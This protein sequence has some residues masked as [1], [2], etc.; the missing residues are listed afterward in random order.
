MKVVVFGG[1]GLVGRATAAHFADEP[2]WEVTAV[3]RR[4]VELAGVEH[5][6]LDLTDEEACRSAIA[7]RAFAGTTHVVFAALQEAPDLY[8]G[9]LD[10]DLMER[11]LT[12]FRAAMEP[13][14]EHCRSTLEHVSLL[15]GAKAYG[16][17]VGRSPVPGKEDDGR[18]EHDNFYFLQEDRLRDLAA[19]E[20]WSWTVLRPQIV[21]GDSVG[22]P[23]NLLPAIGAYAAM[24]RAQGRALGFPGG[25]RSVQE[26][27]D[28]RLL[29]R[30]L[31]WAAAAPEARDEVFNVTNGDVFDWHEVWPAIA[32]A[33][34]MEVGDPAPQRLTDT[35]PE[36]S[37]EWASIVDRHGLR[38]PRDLHAFVGSSWQ[39]GDILLGA[40][41]ERPLPAL[42]STV[43]IRRAGFDDCIDTEVMF[44]EWFAR[45][46]A[47][48]MLPPR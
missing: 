23:M 42:L 21:F 20:S 26:A 24:E 27:V 6:P 35:M 31:A 14:V 32:D 30:A 10:R 34:G 15:Q 48:G 28:V 18:V 16:F 4:P 8:A 11:N 19:G 37:T 43:K 9:W 12:M 46:Q 13:L 25:E 1:S 17:H 5:V 3:S 39:Y 47:S 45:L 33:L 36:R 2:G 7:S 38:A 22:S 44:R 41:G 29:A 40:M